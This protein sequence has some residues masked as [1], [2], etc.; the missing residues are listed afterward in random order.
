M[1][2]YFAEALG[3]QCV[4]P[5]ISYRFNTPDPQCTSGVLNATV[6]QATIRKT[7][8]RPGCS[9][10]VRPATSVTSLEKP[11]SICA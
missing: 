11:A 8:C 1:R 6:T 5:P 9:D 10:S 7:I 4:L 3:L 2:D